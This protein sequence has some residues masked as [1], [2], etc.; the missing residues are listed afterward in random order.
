VVKLMINNPAVS[1]QG[2]PWG[3]GSHLLNEMQWPE[4]N[5]KTC[6]MSICVECEKEELLLR[7]RVS[8]FVG[9]R[10]MKETKPSALP[11]TYAAA[12]DEV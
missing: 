6:S 2:C 7:L 5:L 12:G 10:Y 8:G 4:Y 9:R 3:S 1:L 11:S